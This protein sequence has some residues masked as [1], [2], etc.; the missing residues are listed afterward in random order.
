MQT[1]TLGKGVLLTESGLADRGTEGIPP[2]CATA[3]AWT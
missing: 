3:V 2:S 1:C